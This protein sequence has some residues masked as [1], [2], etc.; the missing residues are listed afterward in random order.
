MLLLL[1]ATMFVVPG[2]VVRADLQGIT[3]DPPQVTDSRRMTTIAATTR[4]T[5]KP[6]MI[7][8]LDHS[9]LSLSILGMSV[10]HGSGD[11]VTVDSLIALL[12][13]PVAY[14]RDVQNLAFQMVSQ[15][16]FSSSGIKIDA[17]LEISGARMQIIQ[18]QNTG[19]FLLDHRRSLIL[20]DGKI[21]PALAQASPGYRDLSPWQLHT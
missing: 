19:G 7:R 9:N 8:S 15:G 6:R 16:A 12:K 21:N 2:G 11:P 18:D 13:S 20:A 17:L 14:M 10:L 3:S 1:L 5:M 4:M